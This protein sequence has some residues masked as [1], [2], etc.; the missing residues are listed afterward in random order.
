MLLQGSEIFTYLGDMITTI[1]HKVTAF[2][3]IHL[4]HKQILAKRYPQF[5]VEELGKRSDNAEYSYS[6]VFL[7]MC[8]TAF[9]GGDCAEDIYFLK[10]SFEPL[11]DLKVPS[12]DRILGIQ[13]EL[14]TKPE[15]IESDSGVINK[16]NV[17][18]K[19]NN[20]LIKTILQLGELEKE[21][22]EYC[23]DFD[24]QFI[25][26]EKQDT[27]WNYK[28]EKGYFPGVASINNTPIYIENRNGNCNVKFNQLATIRRIL[29]LLRANDIKPK[30][31]RMDCGSYLKDLTAFL[32]SEKQ[33]F[34]IR[35][36]QSE[37][38]LFNASLCEGWKTC[39]IGVNNYEVASFQHKFGNK[40]FRIVAYRWPNKSGQVSLSSGDAN[41]YLFIITN[42]YQWDE[43]TIIK[44]YN[45]RGNSERLFDI[46][47]NDFNWNK[48]PFSW[49]EENTVYLILMATCHV[50]YK[51]LIKVF[52][53]FCSF[54]EPH[55]RLK[56]FTFRLICIAAKIIYSGRRTVVKLFTKYNFDNFANTS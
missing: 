24:H 44:F 37:E 36:E 3:G 38:L 7:N 6:D 41:N 13:K 31:W 18:D 29:A 21:N 15:F 54:L 16:I 8:Y 49:L 4:V 52:S 43:E 48:L 12:A 42:D 23:V 50:V 27:T 45:Q 51:W 10:E 2:G 9:C 1:D 22:Q 25:P 17:N 33:L 34:Y 20:F 28:K 53:K 30:R 46:Q 35:A 47:N 19:L 11:K 39:E 55:F 32:D 14:S 56:K 26:C 5:I 40:N